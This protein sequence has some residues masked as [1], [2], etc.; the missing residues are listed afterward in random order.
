MHFHKYPHP[1]NFEFPTAISNGAFKTTKGIYRMQV[2]ACAEDIYHFQITGKGWMENDSQAE[3]RFPNGRKRPEGDRTRLIFSADGGMRWESKNGGVLL[4]VPPGRFFGQ[5]GEASIF[6]FERRA[7]D[8]FYGLGEKWTGFEHSKKTTK[9]WNTDVFADFHRESIT[10]GKPDPDPVYVSIP[11]LILKR[12][13][14]Y[15]GLLLDNPHATF[16]ST[17]M[18][19]V[20]AN[21]MDLGGE[22]G[23]FHLGAERGR[24]SLYILF[25]PSL[26]ELTRK[27]QKLVGVTPCPPAWALGYHQ[28]RWGYQSE[29]DLNGLDLRFRGHGIPVDGLWLDIDYMDRYKVF[30]FG[31]KNFRDPSRALAKLAD[32]GRKV[33]PIIDPGVKLEN[34][35]AVYE[36]GKKAGVFCKNPQNGDYVGLVWPGQT[37]F[38]D[39]SLETARTWW[40]EEVADFAGLGI[41]G[42]WL[43][44]NDPSTGPVDNQDMLFDHGRKSHDSYHNQYALGMA[45]ATREGFLKANPDERP[46]LLSRSGCTGS[47][48]YTAIWTGDNCSNYHHLKNSIATTLNL[49]LSGIPFNAPD[50]GG[51]ADDAT[52]ELMVDWFK[53]GFLFPFFRNHAMW[54]S[55][56][57][58]PWAFGRKVLAVLRRYIRLRYRF[59]PYLYQLFVR[60]ER[61]GEAILRPLFYDFEDNASLPL[62]LVDDQFMVGPGVMQAP[63]VTGGQAVREV[64]LPGAGRWYS[65]MEDDWL[66]GDQKRP[67]TATANGTPLYI[68]DGSILPLARLEPCEQAFH[69]DRVDFHVFLSG[70][71]EAATRYVFD[72][73]ATFA[74]QNGRRSEVE[75]KARRS[76]SVLDIE[77]SMIDRGFG[78]G[79]FTFSSTRDIRRVN[80]NGSRAARCPVQGVP[81]GDRA[82]TTWKPTP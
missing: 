7:G 37:V 47:N 14:A 11:Y 64:I 78:E 48:R 62:G 40:A 9:F 13:N 81:L 38:P 54:D 26:A 12:G 27:L 82:F 41:H 79:D 80:V 56:P 67:V 61:V 10:N 50:A 51:F 19:T 55:R 23:V 28:C 8:Q 18:R 42:A 1:A 72:D 58:E 33:V 66:A 68:R 20:I 5:C 52:P 69:A 3:L 15:A 25:G 2:R 57:Q 71:M 60:Q 34:G 73:G 43:D 76:G 4:S 46:F 17:Q 59:R 65:V 70:D 6:E 31:K 22:D 45:Q 74:Y 75:I 30:T 21:Q 63:F 29:A 36:R 24:P 16:V 53:A 32:R 39:F 77:T 49:G 44:M 35:Y